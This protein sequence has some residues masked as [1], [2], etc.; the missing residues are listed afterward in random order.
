MNQDTR[1]QFLFLAEDLHACILTF[2]S[3]RDILRCT[4][5]S[6]ISLVAID[7]PKWDFVLTLILQ[8]IVELGGQQ[9]LPV[10]L[11]AHNHTPISERLR[12]LRDK[13]HA[14]FKFDTRPVQTV[15]VPERFRNEKTFVSNGHLCLGHANGPGFAKISSIL[16]K[17]TKQGINREWHCLE[18]LLS[19]PNAHNNGVLIDPEQNLAAVVYEIIGK[20][21]AYIDLLALDGDGSHPRAVGPT[22]STVQGLPRRQSITQTRE[23]W[24][25]DGLGRHIALW[26]F[27]RL[28]DPHR[29]LLWLQI[30]DWQ[31][32]TT[33]NC[34]LRD[35]LFAYGLEESIDSCFLGNNRLL[36][37]SDKLKIYS[38]E[39]MSQAPQLL[40]CFL[41]PS[42]VDAVKCFPTT[43]NIAHISQTG[44]QHTTW[45]SD[46]SDRVLCLLA[47]PPLA[48]FVIS[49]STFF[50][51][52]FFEEMAT[53]IPWKIWGP[54]NTRI[55]K[56]D[57]SFGVGV[58]GSRVL[59]AVPACC[60]KHGS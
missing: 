32:S 1:P 14:W 50:E 44:M 31:H 43:D 21:G 34:I 46:P 60:T 59:R 3:Y 35:T 58:G 22:L 33:S 8:Y 9:L 57:S 37:A 55:F 19:V 30:W 10:G 20:S 48:L 56:H 27:L 54:S 42:I 15:V 24:R 13:A 6:I 11:G 40:A 5:A 52:D 4:S 49:T 28:Y 29:S 23:S 12:L 25:L 39:D 2:L 41:L 18:S 7:T 26:H 51:L 53:A 47:A 45:A 38:I 16:P 36:I 17:P